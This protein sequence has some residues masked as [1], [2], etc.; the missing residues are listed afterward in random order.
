[1][2]NALL[3]EREQL[4]GEVEF[5]RGIMAQVARLQA[6]ASRAATTASGPSSRRSSASY[7]SDYPPGGGGGWQWLDERRRAAG[8]GSVGGSPAAC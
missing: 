4:Q 6:S 3:D 8:P 2:T 5:L 1:M 7:A